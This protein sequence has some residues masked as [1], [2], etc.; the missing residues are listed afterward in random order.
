VRTPV[1][2]GVVG[3]GERGE[4][5]ARAFDQL[6]AAELR[7][8]YDRS[9]QPLLRLR[10]QLRQAQPAGFFEEM[11]ADE[12]LDAIAIATPPRDHAQLVRRAL[13]AGKH[14]FVESPLAL[15]GGEAHGL[16][17]RA[18]AGNRQLMASR[19]LVFLP[20]AAALRDAVAGGRLG[21]IY[22]VWVN[23][24]WLGPRPVEDDVIWREGAAAVALLLWLVGDEPIEVSAGGGAYSGADAPEVAFCQLRFATGIEAELRLSRLEARESRQLGVVG[25]AGMALLDELDHERPLSL[26]ERGDMVCPRLAAT[27]ALQ[28]QCEHFLAAVRSPN[29]E[30]PTNFDDTVVVE[31]LEALQRSIRRGGLREQVGAPAEPPEGVIRLPLRA[32]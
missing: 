2:V 15:T 32:M 26:Y 17:A 22:Y 31:A 18:A 7:W 25:S 24:Q 4:A 3:L 13:D 19:P 12:S 6:G 28:L 5:L 23:R 14:V 20:A 27:D 21:E 11:L 29:R 1:S 10:R 16:A 9:R 30:R 8:L